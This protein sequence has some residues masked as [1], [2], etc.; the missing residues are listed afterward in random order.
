MAGRPIDEKIVAMKMDN[1]DFKDKAAETTS[2]FGKLQSA[3]NK[4]P[5]VN[6]GK[7]TQDLNDIQKAAG[8]TNLDRIA[9]AAEAVAGKFSALGVVAITALTNITNKAV[10]AG[11]QML[12]SLSTEPLMDGFK[13]YETKMGSIQTILANTQNKGTTLKDVKESLNELN[14]YA[15]KTIYSFSDMTRNIGL[16]TN[17]GLGLKESTAMIKGF[18]NAAA[19]S[20]SNAEDA[21]RAAYQLSQGLSA[22]YIMTQDWMSLTNAG[23]GN[24]NMKR[25][26]INI[27]M[28]MGKLKNS[29]STTDKTLKNWKESLTKGKWLTSDVM[30]LYL[31]AMTGDM[32]EAALMAKGLTKAQADLLIQ[33]AK[34]GN[35]AATYVRTFTQMMGTIR[36]S[37]GSGWAT[38]F[39]LMFGD[40]DQATK[41]WT[42]LTNVINGFFTKQANQRNVIIKTLA[43]NGVFESIFKG[44]TSA[45]S[46]V[47][48][49][50]GAITD[51]FNK[52]FPPTNITAVI[53]L[54]KGFKDFVVSLKPSQ[55]TLD[56]ISVIFQALFSVV[57]TGINVIIALGKVLWDLIPPNLVTNITGFL[58]YFAKLIISFTDGINSTEKMKTSASGLSGVFEVMGNGI[59]GLVKILTSFGD[60]V[61]QVFSILS[62]G[63]FT[64]K[65]P[66]EEDSKVVNALLTIREACASI[67]KYLGSLQFTFAP[68]A[69]GF[70]NFFTA[71]ANGFNWVVDAVSN[72][73]KAIKDHMPSGQ[74]LVAGGF[75]AGLAAIAWRTLRYGKEIMEAFK[76]WAE[77]GGSVKD[78]IDNAGE[79]L[80]NAGGA[81]K[82]FSAQVKAQA[83]LTIAIAVGVLAGAFLIMSR[84]N[85]EQVA[86]GLYA[87]VGSLSALVGAMAIMTKYDITGTGMKAAIQIVALSIAF[88]IMA[89]ALKK[90]KD[91]SWDEVMRGIV[92]LVG[93]TGA[94]AGATA[95]MSKFGGKKVG[96]SAL[97]MVGIAIALELMISAVKKIADIDTGVLTKGV[98]TLGIILLEIGTFLKLAGGTGFG[99]GST[100]GM[101]AIGRAIKNITSAIDDISKIDI[102]NLKVGLT[103][104]A[105]VLAEVALFSKLTNDM[106]LFSAGVGL[107]LV[108]AA[109]TA[110]I[111]PI[112]ILGNMNLK[113]LTIGLGAMAIAL[114]AIG[115]ASMLMTGMIASGAGLLL[116][117]VALTALTIPIAIMGNM[118]WSTILTGIGGLALGLIVIGGVSA[119]LGLVSEFILAFALSLTVLGVAIALIGG[120]FALFTMGLTGLAGLTIT[121]VTSILAVIGT[122]IVGLASLLPT[123]A[124]FIGQLILA[125]SKVFLD[126][127][128][129]I[130]ENIAKVL[131]VLM[132]VLAKWAP[133]LMDAAANL[134][135]KFIAGMA[136]ALE[137]HSQDII[138]AVMHLMGEILI[139]LIE[140]YTAVIEAMW[141]WIPGVRGMMEKMGKTGVKAIRDNFGTSE[142]GK[143]KG[144]DLADGLASKTGDVNNAGKKLGQSAKDGVSAPD[145]VTPGKLKGTDF[146]S[147]LAS[148]ASLA[149]SSGAQVGQAGK[150]GANSIDLKSLGNIK[151]MDFASALGATTGSVSSAGAKVGQAGK[152][153]ADS[154][155]LTSVGAGSGQ[156]FVSGLAS[157]ASSA[158]SSGKSLATS[159]KSGA[160]SVSMNSTGAWFGQGFADGV[161]STIKKVES[162]ASNLA[163]SAKNAV[164]SWLH[165]KSPSRVAKGLGGFFGE[166]LALGISDKVK[167]VGDS[168]KSLA[169]TAKD[170]LNQFLDGF[171]LPAADS[172][173]HFKAVVDYDQ[174]DASKF[175]SV[176]PLTI[177]P[178]TSLTNGLVTATKADLRQNGDTT[179][180]N[181]DNSVANNN[182]YT[183]NVEAKGISTRAEIKKLA[184]QIQT[185]L[186]NLNDRT[187][188]SRGEGV[189]F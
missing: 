136:D 147:G 109:I 84:L 78:L 52:A 155:S 148:S 58:A 85:G 169:L 144:K 45:L 17:A 76:K 181:V 23:M 81:L 170:S 31:Q 70:S 20:G 161:S 160:G 32:N 183:I 8:N 5:G 128:P 44:L 137:K 14:T 71:I 177:Q 131:I 174:L 65:G 140:G 51:G 2:L 179:T 64:G 99:I 127:A 24:D 3:L 68:I 171:E 25:D 121:A 12:H 74:Q 111:I 135:A 118:K 56:N 28:A 164:K 172:E 165:I 150:S 123:I 107:L 40:F 79:L 129:K 180:G 185:E 167:Q 149:T 101:L 152:S 130:A 98:I 88:S 53:N 80:E 66:W 83:L 15:D 82:A 184:Q 37:I 55:E 27:A 173:L 94:F 21:A 50:Y 105:V 139:V 22:G 26:L 132:N 168:A 163:E 89:G 175:G 106:G 166:G 96:V 77:I 97:Q 57:R 4:I 112:S 176:A 157:K 90:F 134:I 119:L 1:S 59:H 16:F 93:V 108:S 91:M 39:E 41:R 153:G 126:Y 9:N 38:S 35:E 69:R 36:E 100:L 6:L 30:S 67:I 104:I 188:I 19:A 141:G 124:K 42:A 122:F 18:S 178:D 49:V 11:L 145:Y 142:V 46:G 43:D 13:E 87:I 133:P 182:N 189:A 186:K 73:G 92:G 63:D 162:A 146:A 54:A 159:G 117:A 115:G 187:K 103:T 113:T 102:A 116:M 72:V 61:S 60:A 95:L 158:T 120:G 86:N 62:K 34:T 125:I 75:L 10:D 48:K 47:A 156:D 7:T 151:G 29:T 33:N 110:L 138:N 154:I 114:V 143:E